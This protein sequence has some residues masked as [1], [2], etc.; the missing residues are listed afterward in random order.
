MLRGLKARNKV[1][2][3]KATPIDPHV[4]RLIKP[5]VNFEDSLELV[6]W[7]ALLMGF[8][9]LLWVSNLMAK[10]RHNFDSRENLMWK[11][12]RI[13]KGIML[14]HIRWSKT[15][16]YQER[17]LLIPVVPFVD[18]DLSAVQW[19]NLMCSRIPAEPESPAFAVP[20]KT[21]QGVR[22][23]PL[24]YSQ[25]SR[26]LKK[27]TAA[28]GL[29]SPFTTHCLRRGGACWL[30]KKGV[31]DSVI[32]AIGDWRTQTFLSYIDSALSTRMEAMIAFTGAN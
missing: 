31:D 30:K 13:H 12:F 11:D 16:Q 20:T 22:L 2:V 27:W 6:A 1:P 17:K 8:H 9:L 15:L 7:V 21:S 3:K 26:L 14:V 24:S 25:L 28:A 19:F 32:Q 18:A 10:S 23:L 5:Q 29:C 4:F